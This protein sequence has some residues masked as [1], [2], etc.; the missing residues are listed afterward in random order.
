MAEF[1]P[2]PPFDLVVFGGTGDLALRKLFPA[3]AHRFLDGQ[4]PPNSRLI[5]TARQSMDADAFRKLVCGSL[6]EHTDS[7]DDPRIAQFLG[8]LDYAQLDVSHP[9]S[10]WE[11]LEQALDDGPNHGG[12][13]KTRIFYLAVAPSL[14][15]LI[16]QR[17][18]EAGLATENA[19]IVLEKPIGRD[20][21]SAHAIN[22]GVG[23]VFDEHRIF[24]IDHYL[25]KETV[26]NLMVLRFA[27][28]LFEPLWSRAAID[29]V[30]IT[31]AESLGVEGR[32]EYYDRSGALRDMVQNHILQLLCLT[33]MEP[34]HS[35]D[36]DVIRA[37]KLKVL[38]ALKPIGADHAV[39][40]VRGQYRGG[41]V[42]GSPA[43]A[44]AD[45]AG[46]KASRTE[47]FVAIKAEID[48]WRWAGVPFYLRTGKRMA[49]RRSEIIVQFKP[50]PV[51][52]FGAD[53][54]GANRLVLRLQPD[55]AVDLWLNIKEPGPGGLRV[56]AAPLNL[57]YADAF[58]LRYPDAYERL[59]M[60]VARGNLS[61]FMRR[62]EVEAA[63][64]WTES[65]LNAWEASGTAPLPYLA[66]ADGPAA[67]DLLL[68][69]D[70]RAWWPN[71]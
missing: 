22:Q 64:A 33:A 21:A 53:G 49:A 25:G 43:P 36:A 50:T 8:M 67:A 58:T 71:P 48:N 39:K 1:I 9:A 57:S 63:W 16:A 54:I 59:L 26:Q 13:G 46:V 18:G 17:L 24:R 40:T 3:L 12:E 27:N 19:R 56:G 52:V 44:Y 70:G 69:R 35:M 47:T 38:S 10:A 45:E 23:A 34:P 15:T 5:G 37:E 20:L 28:T 65:L 61:L 55:E 32:G 41:L 31:V 29:H 2:V 51:A 30:Q 60:D 11:V 66:G 62:D 14:F 6:R 42:D 68:D 7:A 4:I